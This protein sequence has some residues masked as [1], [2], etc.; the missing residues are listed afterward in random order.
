MPSSHPRHS[1]FLSPLLPPLL[2]SSMWDEKMTIRIQKIE[3][4]LKWQSSVLSIIPSPT[5]S[6][7][8]SFSRLSFSR[9]L[10]HPRKLTSSSHRYTIV[11]QAQE[12][13]VRVVKNGVTWT[14]LNTVARESLTRSLLHA[15]LLQGTFSELI[16]FLL[17]LS[18]FFFSSSFLLSL[19]GDRWVI[20]WLVSYTLT[21]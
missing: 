16:S 4:A 7:L 10:L 15:G 1:L 18:S 8:L 3:G 13:V 21:G 19:M 12:D 6:L 11:L 9:S 17:H 2:S 14:T 5:T 20:M